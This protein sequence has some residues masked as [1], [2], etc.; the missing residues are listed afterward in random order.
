MARNLS[1]CRGPSK[2]HN[3]TM[4]ISHHLPEMV[5]MAA[6]KIIRRSASG[7]SGGPR[8]SS[9]LPL[10]VMRYVVAVCGNAACENI[11]FPART[12]IYGNPWCC[13]HAVA[14]A[15]AGPPGGRTGQ[16]AL[17]RGTADGPGADRLAGGPPA[18]RR[19]R[20]GPADGARLRRPAGGGRGEQREPVQQDAA[21]GQARRA[22][23]HRRGRPAERA[24]RDARRPDHQQRHG[25]PAGVCQDEQRPRPGQGRDPAD[26]QRRLSRDHRSGPRAR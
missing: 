22:A 2:I 7:G 6:L 21:A 14:R 5:R 10:S 4:T 1:L 19:H 13:G 20:G 11:A 9:R 16:R 18:V 12:L 3:N 26:R 17:R 23:R 24:G 25:A 8:A 15:R